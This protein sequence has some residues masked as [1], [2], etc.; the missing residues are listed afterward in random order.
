[1]ERKTVYQIIDGERDYQEMRWNGHV[2][3]PTEWLVFMEDYINEAK[4]LISRN[5]DTETFPT[6]MAIIRKV[7]AMA[8]A[9]MEQHGAPQR[10]LKL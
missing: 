1:M 7:G 9:S 6:I 5:D 4:H 3:T 8:V 10:T 2:H